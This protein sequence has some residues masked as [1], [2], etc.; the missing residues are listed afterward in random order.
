MGLT[1]LLKFTHVKYFIRCILFIFLLLAGPIDEPHLPENIALFGLYNR[2]LG[3]C[4][5]DL[6]ALLLSGR[7]RHLLAS[8]RALLSVSAASRILPL[9]CRARRTSTNWR[10][11]H[12]RVY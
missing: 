4:A 2:I 11:G 9:Y 1:R 5:L 3:I 12:G 10:L 8:R 7:E 6:E